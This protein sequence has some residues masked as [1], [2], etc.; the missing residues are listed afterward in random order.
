M[1]IFLYTLII[2]AFLDTFIQLPVISP[3][4]QSL[5]ASNMLT[6]MI[7]AIYSL[8]NMVGNAI[9]GHWIDRYGRKRILSFGMF[10]VAI[11]LLLYPFANT[12]WELFFT[13]LIHGLAGGALIPA[14]F[15]YLGDLSPSK[16]RGKS[17]AFTGACIGTAAIIGP[18]LGGMISA[19]FSIDTVFI[20]VAV[21]FFVTAIS[22]ALILKESF[23]PAERKEVSIHDFKHLLKNPLMLQAAISGFSLMVSMG[24]L[25]YSLPL[26]M[27]ALGWSSS[28]TGILISTFGIIAIIIFIT[29]LNRWF[30]RLS[31]QTFIIWGL[32]CVS[33]S[34]FSLS[35]FDHIAFITTIMIVYGIG[36]SFIF[37]SMNRI[38][39]E[40]SRKSDRG[41]AFGIF[42][43][44]FSLG[45]V[46]GSFMAGVVHDGMGYPLI[47]G[48]IFLFFMLIIFSFL[49][50]RTPTS[51]IQH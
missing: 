36:F 25:T 50:R 34:L 18:A 15:A 8:A 28:V 49:V 9:S 44:S 33:L 48:A 16:R 42:Y 7:I 23:K 14:A 20:F 41:K 40:I 47:I 45:V 32:G 37:P 35:L 5:G 24:V 19:R 30:D 51:L 46:F 17:M 10:F 6:G 1:L 11:T 21:L 4:A 43:A 29:P 3:Y 38:V 2:V 31:P 27:E 13:R 26:K 22:S 39:V 12:G